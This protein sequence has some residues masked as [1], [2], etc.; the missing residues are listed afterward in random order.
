MWNLNDRSGQH[1]TR[2]MLAAGLLGILLSACQPA[3]PGG[4]LDAQSPPSAQP[5]LD[6]LAVIDRHNQRVARVRQMWA[7][8]VVEV[9]WVDDQQ[10]R[11]FEQGE[12]PLILRKPDE[13][14]LAIGK[15][16]QVYFWVGCD[17]DRYWLL[18]LNPADDQPRTAYVGTPGGS[19]A[20]EQLP[21]PVSPREL[22]NL[23]GLADI[24]LPLPEGAILDTTADGVTVDLPPD[25]LTNTTGRLELNRQ[26]RLRRIIIRNPAG[27]TL[28]SATLARYQPMTIADAPPGAWPDVP[29]LIDIEAPAR[30]T[31][32]KLALSELTDGRDTQRIKDV[33][34]NL[35]KLIEAWGIQRV[36]DL[37]RR[38]R[39]PSP[40]K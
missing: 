19:A 20:S 6:P 32:I 8:A 23:I 5:T 15:L 3:G 34:F 1:P 4:S 17:A 40:G 22:L 30:R 35:S 26:A 21:L 31:S 39:T 10:D 9:E 33:Q 13:L 27:Q 36:V 12:G 2:R 24:P 7:R 14:A 28:I 29:T 38:R 11:H 18:S 25:P 16:E 37:D